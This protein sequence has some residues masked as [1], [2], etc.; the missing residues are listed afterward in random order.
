VDRLRIIGDV[1]DGE[2][3]LRRSHEALERRVVERTHELVEVNDKLRTEAKERERIED[4]LRQSHK[5]EAVGQLTGG[6]AHDF[7]NLLA[8]ISGSLEPIRMR[9]AQGRTA[10][11]GRFYLNSRPAVTGFG[12]VLT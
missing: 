11:V 3:R 4:T 5:M 1:R 7:N 12:F 8:G 2:E 6:L 9:M 10:E